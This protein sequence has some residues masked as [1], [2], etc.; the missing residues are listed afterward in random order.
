VTTNATGTFLFTRTAA[1]SFQVMLAV[2]ATDTSQAV[3]S[4]AVS[5]TVRSQLAVARIGA[6]TLKVDLNGVAGQV[7]QIQR[8]DK[9]RW[10]LATAYRAEPSHTVSR[11]TL[12]QRYRVVVPDTTAIVG[13]I[14]AAVTA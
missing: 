2:N 3:T 4:A 8:Y 13:A 11:L 9:N 1:S 6:G 12:G 5:Y 7:V 10:V 14:S